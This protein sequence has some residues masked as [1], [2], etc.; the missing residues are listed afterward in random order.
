MSGAARKRRN[1]KREEAV[2]DWQRLHE[3]GEKVVEAVKQ[4]SCASFTLGDGSL[5]EGG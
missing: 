1:K 5:R 3:V 2:Q 4:A